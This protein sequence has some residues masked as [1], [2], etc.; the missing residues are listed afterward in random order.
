MGQEVVEESSTKEKYTGTH[1]K[2]MYECFSIIFHGGKL[3]ILQV[4]TGISWQCSVTYYGD[5]N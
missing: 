1:Q 2:H 3:L 5:K 4:A